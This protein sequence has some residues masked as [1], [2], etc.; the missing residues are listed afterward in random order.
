[1]PLHTLV[2]ISRTLRPWSEEEVSALSR[3]SRRNNE[4]SGV[5]GLLLYAHDHFLEVLEGPRETIDQTFGRICRDPRH[6]RIEVLLSAPIRE[7]AYAH[8]SMGVLDLRG[9]QGVDRDELRR[10]AD[11]AKTNPERAAAAA[12]AILER[13]YNEYGT[14]HPCIAA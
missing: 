13:F 1:M 9:T 6:T 2:F 5:T 7:R 4:Q 3:A 12:F 8:S 11:D 14:D 10:I